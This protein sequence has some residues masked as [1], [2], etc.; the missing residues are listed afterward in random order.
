MLLMWLLVTFDEPEELP[1]LGELPV[2]DFS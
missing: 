2:L 1:E